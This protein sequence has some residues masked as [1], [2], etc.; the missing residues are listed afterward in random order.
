MATVATGSKAASRVAPGRAGGL[1]LL[2]VPVIGS[3][4]RWRHARLSLQVLL[5]A[6]ALVT[7]LHGFLGPSLAPKNLA[8]LLTWVHYRG[9]LVAVLLGAGNLFCAACPMVLARDLARKLRLPTRTFPRFLRGKWLGLVLF[10]GVLFAYES[11]D[12]WASPAGT[13]ALIAGYFAA[14][15]LVDA[16]FRRA[17]FCKYVCPVGQFNFV[18]STVS[19]LE[20]RVRDAQVCESCTTHDCIRGRRAEDDPQRIVQRGC[21]LDLY[22]PT[23]VGNLDCTFC[24][25][26]AQAC[27]HDNVALA[28][29]LPAEELT[30]DPVR[31]SLG[32]LSRRLDLSVLVIVFA[33]GALLNAFAMV[34]PV[35]AFQAW[36]AETL[37]LASE[38]A[39]LGV[40]FA[41]GLVV[42]PVVLLALTGA[43]ALRLAGS[44]QKLLAH[45]SRFAL[46][47]APLGVGVWAS[48]YAF[49]L[50][51][52]LL[53]VVPVAQSAAIDAGLWL[54]EPQWGRGGLTAAAVQPIE[55]GLLLLGAA[56]SLGVAA[57]I[58]RRDHPAAWRRVLAPWAVLVV[59]ML[60]AAIW[61]LGQPMEMRGT[62]LG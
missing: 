20:V 45:V 53:T 44:S 7:V 61:V 39:V 4:L 21:E 30:V 6:V 56:G 54:G 48:H 22:L 8:T 11:L 47:L 29:R 2:A 36:L 57:A 17:P 32:R 43:A 10:V 18:A 34:S 1:D 31:S 41:L 5:G 49:H 37:G 60:A 35:Y 13:A 59:V 38:T 33:F 15:V 19:P 46:A 25:D 52:G 58:A 42:E 12:L 40:L 9:F 16:L 24:M 62:F 51:T 27:P 14:A 26:C 23:K 50:L 3:F 28:T 55:I